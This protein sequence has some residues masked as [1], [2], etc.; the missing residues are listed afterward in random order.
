MNEMSLTR[1]F[2][3]GSCARIAVI[4]LAVVLGVSCD[5]ADRRISPAGKPGGD[6]LALD[7]SSRPT[8]AAH[9]IAEPPRERAE[10]APIRFRDVTARSGIE[11]VHVSGNSPEKNYPTANGSGVALLDYDGD[12][13]LDIYFATT[14]NFPLSAPTTSQGN[15]LYRNRGDGTFED[16]TGR[17]GVGYRG[18]CHGVT[19]GDV[20]NDGDTDLFLTNFGP[21]VL[22]L[23]DGHGAF[24]EARDCFRGDGPPWSSGAAFLDYDG[25][26]RL[27]LYVTCYG[28]WTFDE[29]HPYCGDEAKGIRTYCSP[30]QMT[31]ARH[32]L[33]HNRGDGTFDDATKS[34]GILRHDGRGLGVVAADVN[35]DGRIDIYVANDMCPKFLFL[36]RG[37]G[38]FEDISDVSGAAVS[39]AGYRQASMGID[40]EDVSGD[41]LPELFA[42]NFENDYNTLYHNIDGRNFQDVS[43][44]AGIVKDSLPYV[45]WGC[46]L[47][48]FDNDGLGDMFVVNGHVDDNLPQLGRPIPQ[49]EPTLVWRNQGKC[50]FRLVRDP[51]PSFAER[52]VARGAAFGD[53]DN[54]GDL[55]VVISRMDTGPAV[56]LNESKTGRWLG[57]ELVGTHSNR[58]AIGALV[59]VRAGGLVLHRQ[60]KGGGSYLS[61]NDP[62]VLVGL[63]AAERVDE[64]LV[65]WPSGARSNVA[66]LEPGRYHRLVEP[67]GDHVGRGGEGR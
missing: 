40:A 34:A 59:T 43:A 35:L 7:P 66:V 67:G 20:D 37:D 29:T 13:R 31:P 60:V 6:R 11:F 54:D 8:S 32:Y 17:T 2:G 5:R 49:A 42:T 1:P 19:T 25:D 23:N 18:F 10:P 61:A 56:L 41:G 58:T 4:L 28:Q 21:N 39:E 52:H 50:R 27:D 14:R 3:P 63:G 12:G 9:R 55:D 24:R 33:Y 51:G 57:L 62:R 22:Y 46:A 64:V 53:L 26:G 15:K 36:N 30:T 47:A 65:R 38:T 16:V 44:S 48:D 45:G